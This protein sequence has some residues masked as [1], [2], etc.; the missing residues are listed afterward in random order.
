MKP[1]SGTI[2]FDLVNVQSQPN[3][4]DCGLFAIA[5]ATELIHG[6]DHEMHTIPIFPFPLEREALPVLFPSQCSSLLIQ[7]RI[8]PPLKCGKYVSVMPLRDH[9]QSSDKYMTLSSYTVIVEV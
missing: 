3:G 2:K 1:Q 6:N 5:F 7:V 9:S 4:S 8:D